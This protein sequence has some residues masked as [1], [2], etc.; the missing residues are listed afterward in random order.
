MAFMMK[1]NVFG[2]QISRKLIPNNHIK[3]E[4]YDQTLPIIT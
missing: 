4:I 1:E 3:M 2:E